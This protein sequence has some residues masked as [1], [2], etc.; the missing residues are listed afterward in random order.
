MWLLNRT[1]GCRQNDLVWVIH[2]TP[3]H[4]LSDFISDLQLLRSQIFFGFDPLQTICDVP[5]YDLSVDGSAKDDVTIVRTEWDA[6][7]LT[8]CFEL[9]FWVQSV[10]KSPNKNRISFND[11]SFDLIDFIG[12]ANDFCHQIKSVRHH[13]DATKFRMP[14]HWSHI[15]TIALG[16]V[17]EAANFLNERRLIL[18]DLTFSDERVVIAVHV[19]LIKFQDVK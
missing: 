17:S 5:D 16:N 3:L 2:S 7:N 4:K 11:C 14:V 12:I 13:A 8:D 15:A 9:H 1:D 6:R 18:L 10:I 19:N